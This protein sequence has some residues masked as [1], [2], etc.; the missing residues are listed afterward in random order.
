MDHLWTIYGRPLTYSNTASPS[1]IHFK[2]R[3]GPYQ[4][5]FI[6][7]SGSITALSVLF[8]DPR[9]N[10]SVP[11]RILSGPFRTILVPSQDPLRTLCVFC[12]NPRRILSGSS[13]EHLWP[14]SGL[15]SNNQNPIRNPSGSYYDHPMTISDSFENHPRSVSVLF[16]TYIRNILG[17][18]QY[19]LR[20]H[21]VPPQNRFRS[22]SEYYHDNR[23]II[24]EPSQTGSANMSP[25]PN[26]LLGYLDP[27]K[28][29]CQDY[30]DVMLGY[31][32]RAKRWKNIRMF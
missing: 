18:S 5:P 2:T 8:Q 17:S 32:T 7:T 19:P 31:S 1:Q 21:S 25:P 29:T 24:T 13:H 16:Q 30:Q 20:I 10:P 26:I 14:P 27:V 28:K 12:H 23:G 22:H 9:R 4:Y 15:I 6:T 3:S 11:I